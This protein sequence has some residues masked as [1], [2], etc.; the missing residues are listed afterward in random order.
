MIDQNTSEYK[1]PNNILQLCEREIIRNSTNVSDKKM[2]NN[3]FNVLRVKL[4]ALLIKSSTRKSGD[5][6]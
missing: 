3:T 5:T 2:V 1:K 4:K 6:K